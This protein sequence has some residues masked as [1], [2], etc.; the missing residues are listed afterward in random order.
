MYGCKIKKPA[1]IVQAQNK[2]ANITRYNSPC[3][4]GVR[5]FTGGHPVKPSALRKIGFIFY[6]LPSCRF[7]GQG[8]A[9]P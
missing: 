4:I 8:S 9:L 1:Q 3:Y 2:K 6:V 5:V 7:F